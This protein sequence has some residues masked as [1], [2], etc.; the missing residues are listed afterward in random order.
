MSTT[1]TL[2]LSSNQ[3]TDLT[4]LANMSNLQHLYLR[5]N[6]LKDISKLENLELSTL[7][8]SGNQIEDLSPLSDQNLNRLYIDYNKISDLQPLENINLTELV[9]NNNQI[10]DL[11]PIADMD[12]Y[13]LKLGNQQVTLP[14]VQV[15][16]DKVSIENILFD[17]NNKPI[18]P[19]EISHD[20][21]YNAKNNTIN[22]T[23]IESEED[24]YFTFSVKIPME[25]KNATFSGVIYQPIDNSIDT[26]LTDK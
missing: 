14:A 25:S 19:K 6:Q 9:A 22:W 23:I 3:I 17:K 7:Y 26:E 15:E 20:G 1:S 12:F 10:T 2:A 21:T 11:T 4:P 18:S 16:T 13:S 8:L 5:N 24:R